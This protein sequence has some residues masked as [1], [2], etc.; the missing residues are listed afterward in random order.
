MLKKLRPT[1]ALDSNSL[2]I[3]MFKLDQSSAM[4]YSLEVLTSEQ[5]LY[6]GVPIQNQRSLMLANTLGNLNHWVFLMIPI[7]N[8]TS[9]LIELSVRAREVSSKSM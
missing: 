7:I 2:T 8:S 3:A 9:V 1:K 6:L 5:C 4:L